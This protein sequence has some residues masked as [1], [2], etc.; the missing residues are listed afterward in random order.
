MDIYTFILRVFMRCEKVFNSDCKTVSNNECMYMCMYI[1]RK[2][3]YRSN[4][5][6]NDYCNLHTQQSLLVGFVISWVCYS[7][8]FCCE[9]IFVISGG[10]FR[11][12]LNIHIAKKLRLVVLYKLAVSKARSELNTG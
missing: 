6:L 1:Y 12:N 5:L 3:D 7:L 11:L 4:R 2:R 9:L 10:L 8:V